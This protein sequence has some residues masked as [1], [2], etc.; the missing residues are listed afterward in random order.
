LFFSDD[1]A[2]RLQIALV[3]VK[4]GYLAGVHPRHVVECWCAVKIEQRIALNFDQGLNSL[5]RAV[6]CG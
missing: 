2:I 3:H 5:P 4:A 1:R 6:G